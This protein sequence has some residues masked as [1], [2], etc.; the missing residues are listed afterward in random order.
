MEAMKLFNGLPATDYQDILRAV[1][2]L[3]DEHRLRD[4]RIWEHEDGIILQGRRLNDESAHYESIL[5]SDDD[6]RGLLEEAYL[7]R[8]RGPSNG[9]LQS[10]FHRDPSGS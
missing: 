4:V 9:L 10:S 8:N 3:L 2:A 6:L 1:G 7:R 5:L